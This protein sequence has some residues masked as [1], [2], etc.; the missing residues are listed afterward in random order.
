MSAEFQSIWSCSREPKLLPLKVFRGPNP[1]LTAVAVLVTAVAVL[2]FPWGTICRSGLGGNSLAD[3]FPVVVAA[4]FFGIFPA[5]VVFPAAVGAAF[6][7]EG[8]DEA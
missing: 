3:A 8:P 7:G 5:V 2:G 1:Q 6:F 4:A